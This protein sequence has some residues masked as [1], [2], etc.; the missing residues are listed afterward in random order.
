VLVVGRIPSVHIDKCLLEPNTLEEFRA[1][2]A[3]VRAVWNSRD[4]QTGGLK[5]ETFTQ[6]RGHHS[7]WICQASNIKT[8]SDIEPGA[9]AILVGTHLERF[10]ASLK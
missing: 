8:I 9:N 10:A 3:G 4:L 5:T 6:A 1:L 2:P 7:G